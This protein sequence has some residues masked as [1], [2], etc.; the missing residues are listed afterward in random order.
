VASS[1]GT[2]QPSLHSAWDRYR[3]GRLNDAEADCRRRLREDPHDPDALH[4]LGRVLLR[5]R[6]EAFAVPVLEQAAAARPHDADVLVA[7]GRARY[8]AGESEPALEPYRRALEIQPD[9]GK[10]R[11]HLGI[12]LLDPNVPSA[13]STLLTG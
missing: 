2:A 3:S 11:M 6:R 13:T 1:S 5:T 4:L 9:D 8:A 7:L 10:A 12:A